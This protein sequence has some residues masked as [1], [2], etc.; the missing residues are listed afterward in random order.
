MDKGTTTPDYLNKN[1]QEVL[2]RTDIPG[3]DHNQVV[4]VLACRDC[5]HEYGANGSD[6]HHRRCPQHDRGAPELS[7][8]T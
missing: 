2:R 7:I 6:I 5:G 4:Y 1:R 3:T 8:D